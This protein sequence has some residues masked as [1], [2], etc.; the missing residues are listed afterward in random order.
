MASLL[1]TVDFTGKKVVPFCTFGSG[2]LDASTRDLKEKLAG[3]EIL[4]GYGVRSARIDAVPAEIDRFLKQG[5]F[6]EGDFEKYQDFPELHP[7]SEEEAALFDAAVDGYPML[8]AKAEKVTSRS[9]SG[10]TEYIFEA[11][12]IPRNPGQEAMAGTV[13]VYVLDMDGQDPV[14]TQVVR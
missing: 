2:G 1:N 4:P 14:F 5:G 7:V 6:I 11:R 12:D 13:K 8:N 10:G 9:V 3:A